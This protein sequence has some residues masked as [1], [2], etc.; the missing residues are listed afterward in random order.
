MVIDGRVLDRSLQLVEWLTARLGLS[1]AAGAPS[2]D[3][4]GTDP[5]AGRTTA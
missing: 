2:D 3:V 4:G 1:D 5:A